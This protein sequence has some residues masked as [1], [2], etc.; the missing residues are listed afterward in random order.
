MTTP[1]ETSQIVGRTFGYK[2]IGNMVYV[3]IVQSLEPE[4]EKVSAESYMGKQILIC[5]NG[6]SL[7]QDWACVKEYFEKRVESGE[8]KILK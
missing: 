6:E 7:T 5:P 1:V 8:Y 3:V 2:G 4:G